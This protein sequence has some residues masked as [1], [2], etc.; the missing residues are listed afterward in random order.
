MKNYNNVKVSTLTPKGKSEEKNKS[1]DNVVMYAACKFVHIVIILVLLT[2]SFWYGN[3]S[4]T[5][6]AI[7]AAVALIAEVLLLFNKK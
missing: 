1:I 3:K 5:V 7:F 6:I 2:L 4:L